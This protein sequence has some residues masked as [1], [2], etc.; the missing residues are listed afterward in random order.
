MPEKEKRNG[1]KEREVFKVKTEWKK[2]KEEYLLRERLSPTVHADLSRVTRE[3]GRMICGC[4]EPT[5]LNQVPAGIQLVVV[6]F[7]EKPLY[8]VSS[9]FKVSS[10]SSAAFFIETDEKQ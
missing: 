9:N 3:E 6:P 8:E 4:F 7:K 5:M 1:E 2:D 10:G